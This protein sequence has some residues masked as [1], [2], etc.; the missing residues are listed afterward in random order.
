MNTIFMLLAF[1]LVFAWLSA[2]CYALRHFNAVKLSVNI[3]RSGFFIEA[4][5]KK[6]SAFGGV[7]KQPA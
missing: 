6:D 5:G 3:G 4:N 7:Y 1:R 2:A